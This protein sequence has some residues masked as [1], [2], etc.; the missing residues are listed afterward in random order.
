MIRLL[1]PCLFFSMG[2][3]ADFTVSRQGDFYLL[4]NGTNIRAAVA[5]D[6]GGELTGFEV[7]FDGQWQELLYRARD[8]SNGPGW[9]GKAPF[10]WPATG[11]SYMP[12]AGKGHYVLNGNRFPMPAHGFAR[13][14]SW[15]VVGQGEQEDLSSLTLEMVSSAETQKFYPF[16]F[17]LRVEYRLAADRLSLVYT[18]VAAGGNDGPMPFSIGNHVTFRAPLIAGSPAGSL[19]FYNDFPEQLLRDENNAFSGEIVPSPLRGWHEIS[20]LPL[21]YAVSLG[22][23]LSRA[24]LLVLDPSGLQLRM[25]HQASEAP[26]SPLILFNLWADVNEGFFSPEPWLGTQ[27]S[28]NSGAGLVRLDPGQ[29]WHWQI[30]IFPSR[31]DGPGTPLGKESP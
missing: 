30:D 13:D 2:V 27:N 20:E 1:L 22:G 5:P 18:V 11:V 9:R 31:G 23:P 25:V 14:Q 24:E 26:S 28:L 3:S 8:Y 29:R 12:G 17:D 15:A 6:Q 19:R 10:L 7:H 21:R 4:D 16:D